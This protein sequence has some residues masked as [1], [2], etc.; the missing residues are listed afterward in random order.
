MILT[1]PAHA[2]RVFL[3]HKRTHMVECTKKIATVMFLCAG[4]SSRD[5]IVSDTS[6]SPTS[7]RP[8]GMGQVIP[9]HSSFA[10]GCHAR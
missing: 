3:I 2:E 1:V 9:G 4:T 5:T 8:V 10:M 6:T 7:T